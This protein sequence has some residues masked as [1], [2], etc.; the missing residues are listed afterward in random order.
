MCKLQEIVYYRKCKETLGLELTKVQSVYWRAVQRRMILS[1]ME[2]IID[3]N[4]KIIRT[5]NIHIPYEL[6]AALIKCDPG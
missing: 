2:D 5:K 3:N 1:Q 6:A 4:L